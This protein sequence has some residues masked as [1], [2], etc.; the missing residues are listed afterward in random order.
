MHLLLVLILHFENCVFTCSNCLGLPTSVVERAKAMA[1][2]FEDA[3]AVAHGANHLSGLMKQILKNSE[4]A[5]TLKK[6][7]ELSA[8]T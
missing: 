2:T 1:K 7:I 3:L 5:K 4:D 8:S 6:L